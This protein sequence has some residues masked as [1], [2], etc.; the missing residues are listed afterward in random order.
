VTRPDIATPPAAPHAIAPQHDD[1]DGPL[2]ALLIVL[3][4]VTGLVDAVSY[5]K[6]GHVFVANMTGN[7]V[8]AGF[9]V[10]GAQDFSV[11]AALAALA[12]FLAGSL[13][14]GRLGSR[15]GHHRVRFLAGAIAIEILLVAVWSWHSPC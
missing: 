6:L 9:A 7:V 2:P 3:T 12:A 1:R 15:T 13:A 14:G 5:L 8:F 4:F 11:S 10:A